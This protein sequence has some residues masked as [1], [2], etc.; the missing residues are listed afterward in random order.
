MLPTNNRIHVR[1]KVSINIEGWE[2]RKIFLPC[3]PFDIL[4]VRQSQVRLQ[5]LFHE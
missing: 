1:S 5:S 3:L 4:I 2:K